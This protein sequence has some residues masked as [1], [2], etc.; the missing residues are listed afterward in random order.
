M[1]F[2]KHTR[3]RQERFGA[4]IFDTLRE[5]VFVTNETG[6]EI[7]QLIKEGKLLSDITKILGETYDGDPMDITSDV[8]GF[9]E[10]FKANGLLQDEHLCRL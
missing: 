7:L 3:I 2:T 9:I 1:N 10:E 4:V 5:K 6:S 8:K